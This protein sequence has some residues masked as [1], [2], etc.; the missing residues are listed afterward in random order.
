MHTDCTEGKTHLRGCVV[1]KGHLLVSIWKVCGYLNLLICKRLV[2]RV[3][4]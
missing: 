4:E 2:P 3:L 1:E